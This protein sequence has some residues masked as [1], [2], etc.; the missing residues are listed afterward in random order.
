MVTTRRATT[1]A[2]GMATQIPD[3]GAFEIIQRGVA[4]IVTV[5]DDEV[6]AA[7]RALWEDTHNLAE[8]AGAAP[9]A[10]LTQERDRLRGKRAAAILCGGNIDLA[11]FRSWVLGS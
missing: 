5:T 11:L 2:D 3:A 9:F 1:H 8:G 4:R 7:I 6:A 10:A